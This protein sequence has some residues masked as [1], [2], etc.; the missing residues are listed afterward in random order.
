MEQRSRFRLKKLGDAGKLWCDEDFESLKLSYFCEEIIE[1]A[2]KLQPAKTRIFRAWEEG[3]EKRTVGPG[4]DDRFEAKL[5]AKY[6]GLCWLDADYNY[7]R[8][9][10]H[11]TKMFFEKKRGGNKYIIFA[12][13]EGFDL[14]KDPSE[15]KELYDGI[16]K[17]QADFYEEVIEYYKDRHDVKC[18][19]KGGEC[20]SDSDNEEDS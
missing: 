1:T 5:V 13:Y 18:Y 11:P 8:V 14:N 17:T 9:E 10:T 6:G 16:M 19:V 15:Q 20:D 7:R 3:W 12:T 2:R 4:G